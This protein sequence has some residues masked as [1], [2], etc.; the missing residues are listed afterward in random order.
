M[1]LGVAIATAV[2]AAVIRI[3]ISLLLLEQLSVIDSSVAKRRR[4]DECAVLSPSLHRSFSLSFS[5][6]F[7]PL[8]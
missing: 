3:I 7:I 4:D 8:Y 2:V 5:L 1:R 6:R